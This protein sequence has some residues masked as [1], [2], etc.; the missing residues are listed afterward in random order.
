[1]SK[2]SGEFGGHKM[3]PDYGKVA[4]PA[5]A[6]LLIGGPFLAAAFV[7]ENDAEPRFNKVDV[8]PSVAPAT[9]DAS[10]TPSPDKSKPVTY[11]T[12]T[13]RPT[14][15]PDLGRLCQFNPMEP[16]EYRLSEE[17]TVIARV[18]T[19]CQGPDPN[20]AF[21]GGFD[22]LEKPQSATS[23]S[24][25]V[26]AGDIASVVCKEAVNDRT[27]TDAFGSTSSAWVKADFYSP[28]FTDRGEGYVPES[29]VGYLVANTSSELHNNL[30]ICGEEKVKVNWP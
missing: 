11:P 28:D 13:A 8:L 2:E 25:K 10:P 17:G 26:Y 9:D 15:I 12:L 24:F 23:D 18:D 27:I 7:G 29:M 19:R 5:L 30:P 6:A 3:R 21:T 1:M 14:D 20:K 16:G 22:A 4:I